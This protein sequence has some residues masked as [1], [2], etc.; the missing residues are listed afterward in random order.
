MGSNI[1]RIIISRTDA[2]GD[3]MLTL[4]MCG[5]IKKYFPKAQIY[6]LG[7]TYTAP[8]ITR[9][10]H[11]HR[12]INYDSWNTEEEALKQ[13]RDIRADVFIHVFPDKRIAGWV[14]KAGVPIRIG[15]SRRW[16]H[17]IYANKR[18]YVKRKNSPLHEAQ[19]NLQLLQGIGIHEI[20]AI[21]QLHEWV[22]F[23]VDKRVPDKISRLLSENKKRII[24]HPKS[25]GSAREWS[26][27]HYAS[28]AQLLPHEE[29]EVLLCGTAKENERIE[30]AAIP[31]PEHVKNI[32]GL[33]SLEE[34][35]ELIASSHAL[36]AASTGPLHIAAACG[37]RAIGIYPV[38]KPMH[39]GRWQPIG[40][41]AV[42]LSADKTHCSA[43][44]HTPSQCVCMNEV[45]PEQVA[46]KIKNYGE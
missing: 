5:L 24:L 28:L 14:A 27:L 32:M 19:L 9:C 17:W 39:P 12:F 42:Y 30:Q 2:I 25:A 38:I 8:V 26:L 43:C 15:T 20:P 13:L 33:L 21:Q 16:F 11:V 37:I 44:R 29:Y 1:S 22:S 46:Q 4:P 40:E 23:K 18:I 45:T 7:R 35:I 10:E 36:V 41:K 6:F 34:Y 31:F 3:V